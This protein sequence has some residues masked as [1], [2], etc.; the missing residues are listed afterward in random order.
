MNKNEY[1]IFPTCCLNLS[2]RVW[3]PSQCSAV[4]QPPNCWQV[5]KFTMRRQLLPGWRLLGCWV[6]R[7]LLRPT[8]KSDCCTVPGHYRP[9][10]TSTVAA[11]AK[12]Q[13]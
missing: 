5:A 4:C 7:L 2:P 10:V 9:N 3:C 6:A 11:A 13:K 12:Q 8:I 1:T